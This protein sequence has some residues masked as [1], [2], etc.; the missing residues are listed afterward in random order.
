VKIIKKFYLNPSYR[1]FFIILL[2][3]GSLLVVHGVFNK[4]IGVK[5]LWE[6]YLGSLLSIVSILIA[7][8]P[9]NYFDSNEN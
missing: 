4:L 2:F 5:S 6:I 9:A 7:A 8:I 1:S 3:L